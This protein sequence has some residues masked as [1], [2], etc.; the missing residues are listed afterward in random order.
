MSI[1]E[2]LREFLS[3]ESEPL[4]FKDEWKLVLEQD[5]P[6]YSQMPTELKERLHGKIAQFISTTFF[7][8]CGDL[9]LTDTMILSV[10]AQ[11]C[12]LV[13][14]YDGKPYPN[15]NTVL[16][17]PSAFETTSTALGPGGTIIERKVAAVGE[18][19]D[20]GTVIL[21]WDSVRNG[22]ANIFDGHNVTFHEFAHQLD[23]MDGDTDGV[24]LLPS[25]AAYQTWANVLGEHCSNLIDR[26]QRRQ[27]TIIDSYGATNPGEF[28]AVATET[29]FEKPKQLQKKRPELYDELKSFYNLDPVKWF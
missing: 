16:L 9:E 26:V 3:D 1:L 25:E 20:D 14:G 17:Y 18:S 5:L 22:A 11:A 15:L 21:A 27:K 13:L 28:F 8:G 4:E 6:L 10:A 2:R 24:P 19:W 29:F 12:I 23:A 7:E